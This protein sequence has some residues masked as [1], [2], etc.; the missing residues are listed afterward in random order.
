MQGKMCR[1]KIVEII[2]GSKNGDENSKNVGIKIIP[3]YK[4]VANRV[5]K[6][7]KS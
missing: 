4:N 3:T 6:S 2:F 1:V 5:L 7:K